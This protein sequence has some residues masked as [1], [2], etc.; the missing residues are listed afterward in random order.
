MGIS[1]NQP[2]KRKPE[3]AKEKAAANMEKRRNRQL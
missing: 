3:K 2:A 1:R